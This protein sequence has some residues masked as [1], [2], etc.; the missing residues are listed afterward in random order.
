MLRKCNLILLVQSKKERGAGRIT[1]KS[2]LDF[3]PLIGQLWPRDLRKYGSSFVNN[4]MEW[5]EEQF[6][7]EGGAFPR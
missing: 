4:R 3:P 2:E 1:A 5:R 6:L 7:E